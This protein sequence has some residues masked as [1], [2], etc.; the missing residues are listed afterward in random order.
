MSD[1]TPPKAPPAPPKAPVKAT[2]NSTFDTRPEVNPSAPINIA[3]EKRTGTF[4]SLIRGAGA[5]LSPNRSFTAF[6]YALFIAVLVLTVYGF[7][8][9]YG[10]MGECRRNENTLSPNAA[11]SMKPCF[12]Y[13]DSCH[14]CSLGYVMDADMQGYSCRSNS[15][16]DTSI[17]GTEGCFADAY[18]LIIVISDANNTASTADNAA[19]TKYTHEHVSLQMVELDDFST[20]SSSNGLLDSTNDVVTLDGNNKIMKVN[21]LDLIDET[22]L[23]SFRRRCKVTLKIE[24]TGTENSKFINSVSQDGMSR[25]H[26]TLTDDTPLIERQ[27][28]TITLSPQSKKESGTITV[29]IGT[30]T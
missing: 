10:S 23:D 5:A 6:I 17:A 20:A 28:T 18:E 1:P 26:S 8:T 25:M 30:R 19:S 12:Q 7:V 3:S 21:L 16:W 14:N 4:G 11:C 2:E 13:A 24:L 27:R 22:K 29:T 9:F 15:Q